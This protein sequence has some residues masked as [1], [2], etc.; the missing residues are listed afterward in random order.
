MTVVILQIAILL[1]G[2]SLRLGEALH[3]WECNSK[4]D[5]NCGEPF[6]N[7]TISL[8][9]CSQRF[10]VHNMTITSTICRKITQRVQGELR[11]IRGCGFFNPEAAGTCQTRA[12]T[13]LVFMHYCQ[14]E[15]EGCNK[16]GPLHPPSHQLFALLLTLL[17]VASKMRFSS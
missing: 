2:C 16:S 6:K 3:C 12:G 9:D 10:L 1:V 11:I 4:Y 15:G 5:P 13:H 8:A 14:C 7:H 17:L